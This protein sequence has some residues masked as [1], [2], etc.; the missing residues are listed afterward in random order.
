MNAHGKV[1]FISPNEVKDLLRSEDLLKCGAHSLFCIPRGSGGTEQPWRQYFVAQHK[2]VTQVFNDR[3][4]F[5]TSHYDRLMD[6]L[7]SRLRMVPGEDQKLSGDRIK[8]L[9]AALAQYQPKIAG[10]P[11]TIADWLEHTS[12]ARS[13]EVLANLASNPPTA[14]RFNLVW[15]YARIV[16]YLIFTDFMGVTLPV[17]ADFGA[18]GWNFLRNIRRPFPPV[19]MQGVQGEVWT[20]VFWS[21][22]FFAQLFGNFDNTSTIR[23]LAKYGLG[24]L[25][26]YV[27]FLIEHPA[28]LDPDGLFAAILDANNKA[29]PADKLSSH[30]I[31]AIFIEF[32]GTAYLLPGIAFCNHISNLFDPKFT[33]ASGIDFTKFVA[34]LRQSSGNLPWQTHY[35]ELFRLVPVTT[36]VDRV[37]AAKDGVDAMIDGVPIQSGDR[38]TLVVSRAARDPREFGATQHCSSNGAEKY[39]PHAAR[40]YL[41]FRPATAATRCFGRE[42]ALIMLRQMT[43]AMDG[44]FV[45]RPLERDGKMSELMEGIPDRMMVRFH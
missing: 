29:A 37:A 2:F 41:E 31:C 18:K 10:K 34:A 9:N 33:Q 7:G 8:V 20:A 5:Q 26:D 28:S 15:D 6:A 12:A 40:R 21:Q 22:M 13:H 3:D 30:D 27:H 39:L 45:V 38:V 16:P 4:H 32:L 25:E 1:K 14:K 42:W 36:L 44:G 35:D 23:R 43:L 11:V 24:K 17:R 19:R